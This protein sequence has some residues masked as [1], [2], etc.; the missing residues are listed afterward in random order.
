MIGRL[1]ERTE[2]MTSVEPE[3]FERLTKKIAEGASITLFG[4]VFGRGVN[5]FFNILLGRVLGASYY[6]I[7]ALG[8]SIVEVL[9]NFSMLG[10]QNGVVRYVS[11]HRGEGHPDRVKGTLISAISISA[12]SSLIVGGM[13]FLL[14]DVIALKIFNNP[15][16][17]QV[18]K[19]LSFALPFNAIVI[20]STASA[21][22]FLKIKYDVGVRMVFHPT[23]QF[24]AVS[25]VFLAGLRLLGVIYAVVM[26]SVLSAILGIYFLIKI[27]PKIL[28]DL[29]P[30]YQTKKLLKF[31]I[32]V[33]LVGLSYLVLVRTDRLMLGYL[34]S[35][36]SV[37]IYNAAAKVALLTGIVLNSLNSIFSPMIS[38]LYNRKQIAL[39]KSLFGIVTKWAFSLTLSLSIIMVFFSKNIMNLFGSE[40]VAGWSVLT[41]LAFA[42][43]INAGTGSVGYML[44]MSG[45]QNVELANTLSLVVINIAL[46]IWFI[47]H[48][49]VV[50]AALAT[51][52]AIIM[53]NVVKLIEVHKMM[54]VHPY[55][56]KFLKPLIAGL[57]TGLFAF[58]FHKFNPFDLFWIIALVSSV[59]VY[60]LCLYFLGLDEEDKIVL[61]A[62]RNRIEQHV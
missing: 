39:L 20:T 61:R 33:L 43:L 35:P 5:F 38:D 50:G 11:L 36:T 27:F 13:L 3:V 16:L 17:R 21:R 31:S 2:D 51:A 53:I 32:P 59:G 28:S 8:Y 22:S 55:S 45:R 52:L 42:Q 10:L 48:F 54:N 44:Q 58:V 18:L 6:G 15:D 4:G 1:G 46:N 23:V 37:G 40:F 60:F 30:S 47:K 62:V 29:Q 34:E 19:G 14:S 7:Y 49:G 26:S 56:A 41:L 12:V 57:G 9:Q 25:L 24:L